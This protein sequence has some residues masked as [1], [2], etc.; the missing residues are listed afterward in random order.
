MIRGGIKV[1]GNS[2]KVSIEIRGG[3]VIKRV[4]TDIVSVAIE[5]FTLIS[6][7]LNK[8][9]TADDDIQFYIDQIEYLLSRAHVE[10][11]PGKHPFQHKYNMWLLDGYVHMLLQTTDIKLISQLLNIDSLLYTIE[12][13]T[14]NE[15]HP[16]A[17]DFVVPRT[18][19]VRPLNEVAPSSKIALPVA[20]D[21]GAY[22]Q[23]LYHN[24]DL[25][26]TLIV[27]NKPALEEI[28]RTI[29]EVADQH[30]VS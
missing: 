11:V 29:C 10:L 16:L 24:I 4:Y 7:M 19:K 14:G 3:R 1:D 27:A 5:K 6:S 17:L 13:A 15:G 20:D 26:N 12:E 18:L 22:M 25:L 2:V 8:L 30:I 23:A 28:Y 21:L 9:H